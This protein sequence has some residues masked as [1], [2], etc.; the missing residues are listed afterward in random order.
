MRINFIKPIAF[1]Y[2]TVLRDE[3][4]KGNLPTVKVDMGGFKL[5]KKNVTNG[6]ML[7]HSQGG[8]TILPN[9]MLESV[10]Y[11]YMKQAEPFSNFF[12]KEGF[13]KYCEQFKGIKLPKF[14][15]DRY[16]KDITE[17]A[18]RLLKKGL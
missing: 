9:I 15:G 4:L 10:E 16:V 13:Q 17:T 2:K 12:T 14:D 7:P 8:K 5:T 6:H 1:Q 3:F 18:E 11:N